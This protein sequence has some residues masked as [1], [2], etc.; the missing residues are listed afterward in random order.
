MRQSA[1]VKGVALAVLFI[2]ACVVWYVV[3]REDRG[4]VLTVSFLPVGQGDAVLIDAPS[5]DQ[6]L[7]DGGPDGSV[8]R[9]LG[10]HIPPWDRSIDVLLV[11]SPVQGSAGGLPDVLQRYRIG[12]IVQTGIQNAAAPWNLFEKE[13][14][15]GSSGIRTARRGD[16]L[17]LGDGA[18]LQILFPDRQ[19]PNAPAS[20]GC[21]VSRLVYGQTA[22][23]FACDAGAGVQNYLAMLDGSALRSD[24]LFAVA[25]TTP[26]LQGYVAPQFTVGPCT[27]TA[28]CGATFVSDGKVVTRR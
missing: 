7:I 1:R 24:V 16:V 19:L 11:T 4:G 12:S 13:A 26:I 17:G 27:K 23:L 5:G 3:A 14:A 20:E 15:A 22:F 25:S 10:A 2:A 18:Y 8:L 28:P 6:V 9:A 21:V